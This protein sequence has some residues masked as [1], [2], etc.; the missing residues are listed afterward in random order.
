MHVKAPG[1]LAY[2]AERAAQRMLRGKGLAARAC[3]HS[4]VR[5]VHRDTFFAAKVPAH[6]PTLGKARSLDVAWCAL[7]NGSE[8]MLSNALPGHMAQINGWRTHGQQPSRDIHFYMC[9]HVY[10]HIHTHVYTRAYALTRLVYVCR[11]IRVGPLFAIL[12]LFVV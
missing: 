5:P 10:L 9:I 3:L 1:V 2:R 8:R 4:A 7:G 6:T 12:L 11:L